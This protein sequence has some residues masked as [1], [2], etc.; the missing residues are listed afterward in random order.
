M[1]ARRPKSGNGKGGTGAAKGDSEMKNQALYRK[2]TNKVEFAMATSS[3]HAATSCSQR[4]GT[5]ADGAE[6]LVVLS[7]GQRWATS[8]T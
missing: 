2:R 8:S 7:F 4:V 3:V 1:M 5:V 6:A